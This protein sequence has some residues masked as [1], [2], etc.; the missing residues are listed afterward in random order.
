MSSQFQKFGEP[1]TLMYVARQNRWTT[2]ALSVT[3][4]PEAKKK[5]NICTSDNLKNPISSISKFSL[6]FY[7]KGN[8]SL[9]F[10]LMTQDPSISHSSCNSNSQAT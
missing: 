5:K 6:Q 9:H 10:S 7:L 8:G 1:Q 3:N 4:N 2:K